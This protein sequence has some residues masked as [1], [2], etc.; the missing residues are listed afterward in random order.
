MWEK[1]NQLYKSETN[2]RSFKEDVTENTANQINL[3]PTE[4]T[5]TCVWER[6]TE[7]TLMPNT[8]LDMGQ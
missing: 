1:E 8:T 4:D 3:G 2:S 6:I 5:Q 7:D